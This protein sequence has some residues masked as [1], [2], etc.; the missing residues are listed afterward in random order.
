MATDAFQPVPNQA[1]PAA[2]GV[3]LDQFLKDRDEDA[4]AALMKRHG[5]YILAVC[6]HLT[7]H[8]QDAEDVFQ[9]CFLELV[10]KG[11]SIRKQNSVVGWLHTV[12]VR[13]ARRARAR[14]AARDG[15][16]TAVTAHEPA[17]PPVDLSWRDACR[18]LQEE[19]AQLPEEMRLPIILCF[20]EGM[21]QEEASQAL[22]VNPRTIK[23]RLRR[24]REALRNRLVRRGVTLAI[25]G[26][27]LTASNLQAAVPAVLTQATLQGASAAAGNAALAGVVSPAVLGLTGTSSGSLAWL[28]IA[29]SLVVAAVT[30]A[31]GAFVAWEFWPPPADAPAVVEL[32]KVAEPPASPRVEPPPAP[33]KTVRRSFRN[34]QFDAEFFQWSGPS[35]KKYVRLEDE[36]LRV[37]LP[38]KNG[39]ADAVGVKLR[40]PVRGDFEVEA[41][42]EFIDVATPLLPDGIKGWSAGVSVYCFLNSKERD[43]IWFGK[44]ME[45]DKGPSFLMGHRVKGAADRFTKFTQSEPS[46]HARGLARVRGVRKGATIRTF[47]AEGEAGEFQPWRVLEL[48]DADATIVRFAA[49]PVWIPDIA[50][51]V[52]LID[53]A[54]TAQEIVGYAP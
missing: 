33:M 39:P 29:C 30:A 28:A 5:P 12:A 52:R 24:G 21:T 8:V 50:I 19:L 18:V 20:F 27:L 1:V 44:M 53:F 36:G 31:A 17:A 15:K 22:D 41:L 40:Y 11:A 6:K 51:D 16:E 47:Y 13:L 35:P 46:A 42:F 37:T 9:A 49:D 23:D 45:F 25:L 14:R 4:F 10:R 48:S 34:K 26:T 38:A 3:L 43:G 54:I 32:A 2:D 7:S